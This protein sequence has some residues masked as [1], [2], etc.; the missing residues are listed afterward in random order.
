[1]WCYSVP[2][3]EYIRAGIRVLQMNHVLEGVNRGDHSA[4]LQFLLT[5]TGFQRQLLPSFSS[6]VAS[7][8]LYTAAFVSVFTLDVSALSLSI[9]GGALC[10]PILSDPSPPTCRTYTPNCCARKFREDCSCS[11]FG[12]RPEVLYETQ[13]RG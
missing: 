5:T 3:W 6:L 12:G 8:S 1:M 9:T 11:H 10:P 2:L 7:L 4:R 13:R